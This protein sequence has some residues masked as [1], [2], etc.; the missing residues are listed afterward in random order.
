MAA[1]ILSARDASELIAVT[2]P[3]AARQ[4]QRVAAQMVGALQAIAA[5]AGTATHHH[6][7]A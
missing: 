2:H 5:E 6:H 3:G 1:A 4:M 7:G